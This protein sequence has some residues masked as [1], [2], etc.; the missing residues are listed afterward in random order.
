MMRDEKEIREMPGMTLNADGKGRLEPMKK[1]L[2][3][4]LPLAVLLAVSEGCGKGSGERATTQ[5][6]GEILLGDVS[7]LDL[8]SLGG[9]PRPMGDD[10]PDASVVADA[11]AELIEVEDIGPLDCEF[12]SES[13]HPRVPLREELPD[14]PP[15]VI[16]EPIIFKGGAQTSE[17]KDDGFGRPEENTENNNRGAQL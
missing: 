1:A 5:W 15:I 4:G 7:Q 3:V 6:Q 10:I 17:T 2:V 16:A 12:P 14:K 8:G 11:L 9:D 13:V